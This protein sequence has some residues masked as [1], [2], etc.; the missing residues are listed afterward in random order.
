MAVFN[1]YILPILMVLMTYVGFPVTTGISAKLHISPA[2]F[3]S[4][5]YK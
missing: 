2:K 5:S 3:T 1:I 4:V